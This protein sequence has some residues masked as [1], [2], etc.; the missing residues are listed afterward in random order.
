MIMGI[1]KNQSFCVDFKNLNMPVK[2]HVSKK[3]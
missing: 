1:K 2:Q 3:R